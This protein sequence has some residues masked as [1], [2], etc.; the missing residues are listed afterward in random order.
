MLENFL[1]QKSFGN[2]K[3]FLVASLQTDFLQL[4]KKTKLVRPRYVLQKT[5]S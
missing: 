2:D 3:I 5:K 4:K 1:P